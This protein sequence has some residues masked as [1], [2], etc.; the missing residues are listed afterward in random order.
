MK[1]E[2]ITINSSRMNESIRFY[3][4]TA[5]LSIQ[6]D[7]RGKG[8]TNIVFMGNE[9]GE[10]CIEIIDNPDEPYSGEGISIGFRVDDAEAYHEELWKKG[11]EATPVVRPVE[12]GN[13]AFF[14]VKDPN[15]VTVQFI[16]G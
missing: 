10:T 1:I 4:E 8:P 12:G 11:M 2:H 16:S 9:E 6:R 3:S 15:G 14:F 13:V 7:M 5:G